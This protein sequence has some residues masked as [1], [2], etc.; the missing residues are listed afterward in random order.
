MQTFCPLYSQNDKYKA[1]A[2]KLHINVT[3]VWCIFASY[4]RYKGWQWVHILHSLTAASNCY[5]FY[6]LLLMLTFSILFLQNLYLT[7]L[8]TCSVFW[9]YIGVAH[10]CWALW[11]IFLTIVYHQP[12]NVCNISFSDCFSSILVAYL[13]WNDRF[14]MALD[15]IMQTLVVIYLMFTEI[16]TKWWPYVMWIFTELTLVWLRCSKLYLTLVKIFQSVN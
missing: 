12:R 2:N 3:F 10:C 13:K 1:N 16:F 14:T 7:V 9:L 11:F 5:A 6:E 15:A 8:T 4:L